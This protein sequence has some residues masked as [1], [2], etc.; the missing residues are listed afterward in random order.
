MKRLRA[1]SRL[2]RLRFLHA[3]ALASEIA[4]DPC[5][6]DRRTRARRADRIARAYRTELNR[7]EMTA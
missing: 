3:L 1:R 2:F 7:M 5:T 4:A 6:P